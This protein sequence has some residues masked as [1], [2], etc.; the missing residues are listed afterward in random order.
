MEELIRDFDNFLIFDENQK[1]TTGAQFEVATLLSSEYSSQIFKKNCS[2][3]TFRQDVAKRI[4]TVFI[5]GQLGK[6]LRYEM[7]DSISPGHGCKQPDECYLYAPKG[8]LFI[9]EKKFQKT[10]GSTCEKIQTPDFKLWQYR[11]ILPSFKIHYIYC[12][13]SWFKI[14]CKAELEYLEYKRIP[15][16]FA[17]ESNYK[18]NLINFMLTSEDYQ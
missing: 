3:V 1:I 15:Y 11:R 13:S 18:S 8:I 2:E 17:D 9:I 4:F 5:K 10:T 16:F 14:N 7:D 12:L 6:V